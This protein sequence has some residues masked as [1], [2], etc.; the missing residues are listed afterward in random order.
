MKVRVLF[1]CM[2]NICRSPTAEGVFRHHVESAGLSDTIEI[3]SAGTGGWHVGEAP[4]PRS[5]EVAAR[6]G[7]SLEGQSARRVAPE[8][9]DRFDY[10]LALDRSVHAR[11][12]A[13][14]PRWQCV[15]KV[16]LGDGGKYHKIVTFRW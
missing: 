10:V 11:L 1:V 8:D 6:H 14:G 5:Q 13:L 16:T 15:E 12:V 2:G 3:D 9:F 4:D 7:V